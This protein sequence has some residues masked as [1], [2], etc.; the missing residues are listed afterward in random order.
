MNGEFWTHVETVIRNALRPK[1]LA[2][3]SETGL[4]TGEQVLERVIVEGAALGHELR[5]R[6]AQE[7]GSATDSDSGASGSDHEKH[8]VTEVTTSTTSEF[9]YVDPYYVS[10]VWLA[11]WLL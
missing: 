5:K 2:H 9:A 1:D 3:E 7:S 8:T 4:V 10:P 6:E 11:L